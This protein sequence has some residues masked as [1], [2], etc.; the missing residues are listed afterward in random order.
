MLLIFFSYFSQKTGFVI[1]IKLSLME[2]ICMK[3]QNLFS[4]NNEKN[5]LKCLL[6]KFLPR[7]LRVKINIM[8][9]LLIM[10]YY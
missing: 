9:Y 3:C 8:I 4:E 5:I 7:V 6:L 1:S 2:T 10:Y